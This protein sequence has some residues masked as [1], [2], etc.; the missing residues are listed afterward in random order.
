MEVMRM[1][2]NDT[3]IVSN[4]SNIKAIHIIKDNELL[5]KYF[6]EGT[7]DTQLFPVDCIFKSI[8]SVLVGIAIKGNKFYR[9]LYT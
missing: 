7:T 5:Y 2:I 4:H 6:R 8:L 9:R 3:E 1:N